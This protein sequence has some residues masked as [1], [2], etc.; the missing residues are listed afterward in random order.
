MAAHERVFLQ[1]QDGAKF[2][3]TKLEIVALAKSW[4]RRRFAAGDRASDVLMSAAMADIA[5]R[6]PPRDARVFAIVHEDNLRSLA[7]CRR[8]GLV[9]ELSRAHPQYRRPITAHRSSP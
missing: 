2:A 7:L 8:H 4:Q 3:A 5:E 6:V 1:R 9:Q